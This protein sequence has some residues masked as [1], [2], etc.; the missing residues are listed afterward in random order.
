M[1]EIICQKC[2][3]SFTPKQKNCRFCSIK[4]YRAFYYEN[5]KEKFNYLTKKNYKK[6]KKRIREVQIIWEKN[7][8]EKCRQARFRKNR[9]LR[10]LVLN[11]YSNKKLECNCC[12]EKMV[13]FLT[14]DHIDGG[15]SKHR[16]TFTGTLYQWLKNN[17]FPKGFQ[18]LCYNCNQA[19][20]I[21]KICPHKKLK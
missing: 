2:N 21:Y 9:K 8:P 16:K 19:K 6:N 3:K 14:I 1:K 20:H 18:V 5:N 17:N 10:L 15:G 11:E 12:K 4:C 13:E 7:N